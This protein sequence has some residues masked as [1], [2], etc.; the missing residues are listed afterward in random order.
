MAYA[1]DSYTATGGQTDFTITFPYQAAED[2]VVTQ[3]GNT[4]TEGSGNDYTLPN[5]T[6]VRLTSG[7]TLDDAIVVARNTSQ[8]TRDVDFTS[9]TLTEADL[10][11]ALID[12]LQARVEA[13]RALSRAETR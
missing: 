11:N 9:G 10:D 7:A 3:N 6:T 12:Y 13:A 4:L 2:I 8:D 1:R 5:A